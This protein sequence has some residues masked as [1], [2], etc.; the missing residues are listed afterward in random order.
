MRQA[1]LIPQRD[2]VA[3]ACS[4]GVWI[5]GL[6]H[7]G[8]QFVPIHTDKL[9]SVSF[10]PDGKWMAAAALSGSRARIWNVETHQLVRLLP[11]SDTISV[12][13][14]PDG[15]CLVTCSFEEYRFWEMGSWELCRT[16]KRNAGSRSFGHI[17]LDR[18]GMIMA[19][20]T[21]ELGVQLVE[22]GSGHTLA[23]LA[24]SGHSPICFSPDSGQLL[25]I[26]PGGAYYIWDLRL[27]RQQLSAMNLDWALPPLASPTDDSLRVAAH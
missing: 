21:A 7:A 8:L 24:E 25:T 2:Q 19:L 10:S 11:G 13:F 3:V 1:A 9:E 6:D 27:I 17:V 14:S 23:T 26:D 15:C 16:I 22:T 12:G 20:S 5:V 4:E 18:S